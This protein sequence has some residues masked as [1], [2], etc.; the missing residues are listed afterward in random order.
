MA[1]YLEQTRLNNETRDLEH[2]RTNADIKIVKS[3]QYNKNYFDHKRKAPRKYQSGDYVMILNADSTP[4][5]PKKLLPVSKGPYEI[6][7]VLRNDRYVVKDIENFQ[8]TQR[9][10][11]GTWEAC[12]IRP[13]RTD[14]HNSD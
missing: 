5:A 6:I 11:I 4:R 12:N 7:K 2:L 10:Y 9:P 1:E 14:E 8:V 3:Q 13:W